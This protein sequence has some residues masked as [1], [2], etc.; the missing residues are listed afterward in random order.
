MEERITFLPEINNVIMNKYQSLV[1]KDI[2]SSDFCNIIKIFRDNRF[3][4]RFIYENIFYVIDKNLITKANFVRGDYHISDF[5]FELV[6]LKELFLAKKVLE[7]HNINSPEAES[8]LSCSRGFIR[9]YM[10]FLVNK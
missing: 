1:E 9:R 5:I 6:E 10:K 4:R 7:L 8:I 2:L 3:L